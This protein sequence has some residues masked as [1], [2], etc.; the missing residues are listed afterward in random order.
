MLK[1][2]TLRPGL[3]V[4]LSTTI[5]GGNV[6]YS[7]RTIEGA[8]VIEGGA[9]SESWET[10]KLVRNPDELEAGKVARGKARQAIIRHCSWS[11]FG[12]LCPK[13]NREELEKGMTEARA[14]AD[15][16][17][18]TATDSR[19][20]VGILTGEIV[21]NDAQ[22]IAM[23]NEEMRDLMSEMEKGVANLDAKAI[24][25]AASRAVGLG[26]MLTPEAETRMRV[27]VDAARKAARTI[28][29][30]GESAAQEVDKVA[31]RRIQE[32]RLA[33]LDMEEGEAIQAPQ[34][35]ARAIDFDPG[36]S[37]PPSALLARTLSQ[38]ALEF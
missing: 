19:L 13:A 20:Y 27:A 3:L 1:S 6:R 29:K 17:N 5:K 18:D 32:S 9:I 21:D 30:A 28:T 35:T 25:D 8:R 23:M 31:I 14:I 26:Q 10:E 2:S 24:R 36:D 4:S 16:F 22:A 37:S 38:V 7:K 11:T 34:A 12:L 33:F 15:E